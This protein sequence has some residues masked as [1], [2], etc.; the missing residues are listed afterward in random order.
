M[1][2]CA[3]RDLDLRLQLTPRIELNVSYEVVPLGLIG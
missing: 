1:L 3:Q 2:P